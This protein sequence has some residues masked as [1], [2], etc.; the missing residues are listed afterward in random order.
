MRGVCGVYRRLGMGLE[1]L[2]GRWK[3][4]RE[5]VWDYSIF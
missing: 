5:N 1:G 3:C 4:I 2:W